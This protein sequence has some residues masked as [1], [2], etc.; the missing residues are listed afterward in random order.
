M[1]AEVSNKLGAL[2]QELSNL[3][4]DAAKEI[5]SLINSVIRSEI[6]VMGAVKI[7]NA[8]L[9]ILTCNNFSQSVDRDKM[10]RIRGYLSPISSNDHFN[11]WHDDITNRFIPGFK[12]AMG[13]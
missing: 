11:Y 13:Y 6:E 12:E 5:D 7:I 2:S 9:N 4:P 1:K 8:R 3:C 10:D